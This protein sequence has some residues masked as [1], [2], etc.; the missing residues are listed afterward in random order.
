MRKLALHIDKH[1]QGEFK[2]KELN[3][4]LV[5][6]V[7]CPGCF[8]HALPLFQDLY[9]KYSPKNI[10]FLA[11]STAFEDFDKNTL[12]NT[13][14]LVEEGKLIGETQKFF[15]AQSQKTLPYPIDFPIAMD[16]IEAN[17]SQMEAA[18]LS[19]CASVPSYSLWPAFEKEAFRKKVIAYL[20]AQEKTALTFTLHQ[21][22][23]TPSY[24]LFNSKNEILGEWF[25]HLSQ[26]EISER[27]A[28]F[29]H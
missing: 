21:L 28:F 9:R 6:Q 7:N 18:V 4:L 10:S 2:Q 20:E 19:I 23:G 13:E 29:Q 24:L 8:S 11:L 22:K 17:V 26:Q 14:A 1:I 15:A 12:E 16:K 25:G 3:L 5:F 27:I